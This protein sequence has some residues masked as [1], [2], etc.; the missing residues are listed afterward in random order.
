MAPLSD[1]YTLTVRQAPERAR[2]AG[3]KEKERKPVDPPPIVQL[4]IRDPLDLAQNYLQSPYL[5]MCANLCNADRHNPTQLASQSVLSGTLVSSLHRLKDVDNSD[6]GFFVFGDLSVKVEGDYCLRFSLFEMLKKRPTSSGIRSDEFPPALEDPPPPAQRDIPLQ[7]QRPQIGTYGTR[8]TGSG[9]P[10][11]KRQR[12]SVDM[13]ERSVIDP[14]R[15]SQRSYMDQR[16]PIGTYTASHQLAN[17]FAPT[18]SQGPPSALSNLSDF[19]FGHQRTNS[20]NTSSPFVSPHTDFSGHSWP[21]SN[22]YY[23][24]SA[25]DPLYTYSQSQYPDLQPPRQPQL[26]EPF[27]RQRVQD[28]SGRLQMNSNLSFPRPL[29]PESSAV[30]SYSQATRHLPMSSSYNDPSP[31]LPSTDQIGDLA[32]SNRQQYPSAPLSNVLPPLESPAGPSQSQGAQQGLTSNILPS[33]EPSNLLPT[34][35]CKHD[36]A[37]EILALSSPVKKARNP[38]ASA[39]ILA[40]LSPVLHKSIIQTAIVVWLGMAAPVDL[41]LVLGERLESPSATPKLHAK[42]LQV[43]AEGEE[44]QEQ[45]AIVSL[46]DVPDVH[47]AVE[48]QNNILHRHS[49]NQTDL[50]GDTLTVSEVEDY[51]LQSIGTATA[52]NEW[53]PL[54]ALSGNEA[55]A[56]LQTPTRKPQKSAT[57]PRHTKDH[58]HHTTSRCV[59]P[60]TSG[61][62]SQAARSVGRAS[63]CKVTA[64]L[65]SGETPSKYYGHRPLSVTSIA[66]SSVESPKAH[67][68]APIVADTSKPQPSPSN[69]H[70]QGQLGHKYCSSDQNPSHAPACQWSPSESP[71][72]WLRGSALSPGY[73]SPDRVI[74]GSISKQG[75]RHK[76]NDGNNSDPTVCTVDNRPM[77]DLHHIERWDGTVAIY[78]II[79]FRRSGWLLVEHN[80]TFTV[81]N[82][83][84][85]RAKRVLLKVFIRNG[86]QDGGIYRLKARES[87]LQ[88]PNY[89]YTAANGSRVIEVLVE[90]DAKDLGN[91]LTI[92]F[93]CCCPGQKE[94][95]LP[96]PVIA[97]KFG[98]LLSEKIWLRKP[99]P[100]LLVHAVGRRFLS[101][102]KLSER[103][104]GKKEVLCFERIE[105]SPLYPEA[106]KED[107][108]V[109]LCKLRPVSWAG[110]EVSRDFTQEEK[111]CNIIP[112][113]DMSIDIIPE[114]RL[115]CCMTFD[116]EVGDCQ[117]LLTIDA[118]GWEANYALVNG[119]LCGGRSTRWGTSRELARWLED[120]YRLALVKSPRMTPGKL[121][122]IEVSFIVIGPLSD[123]AVE[124]DNWVEI[125]FYLPRIV[126]K[127][128][129][130]GAVACSYQHASVAVTRPGGAD[131]EEHR[132]SSSHGG[133]RKRLPTL[134]RGYRLRLDYATLNPFR[135]TNT[136][137]SKPTMTADKI[138]FAGGLPLRPRA[139]RFDDEQSGTS[140]DVDD[141]RIESDPPSVRSNP[142]PPHLL[143]DP[144]GIEDESTTEVDSKESLPSVVDGRLGL[145]DFDDFDDGSTPR[146]TDANSGDHSQKTGGGT[147]AAEY[148]GLAEQSYTAKNKGTSNEGED[149][150][151]SS[152]NEL[153]AEDHAP[154]DREEEEEEDDSGD[155]AGENLGPEPEDLFDYLVDNVLY[156][157]RYLERRSPMQYL[158]RFFILEC[159]C[160][161]LSRVSFVGQAG[162]ELQRAVPDVIITSSDVLLGDWDVHVRPD[163]GM[164]EVQVAHDP[165]NNIDQVV[166]E[167]HAEESKHRPRGQSLR[168]RLDL[169]LGWRPQGP[170]S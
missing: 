68:N 119:H 44:V 57:L 34:T 21:T 5:F 104:F 77:D 62:L 128:I 81:T 64:F 29:D 127:T 118:T 147:R 145:D 42:G 164:A 92:V 122:H 98:K 33:I 41:Q 71:R 9:E 131:Y 103:L 75:S 23:Q 31:R 138:R 110:L 47:G 169:A 170:V 84:E 153:G 123:P 12:T 156:L 159:I 28:L 152:D 43:L 130:G 121:L 72:I 7:S 124:Q 51:T 83:P 82:L 142:P 24:A 65:A 69:D 112:S 136:M 143:Q 14:D 49:T 48:D 97:P 11:A 161:G 151:N 78:S 32:A 125:N 35:L 129:L 58:N 167:A 89:E 8:Y 39:T 59:T 73:F 70:A 155:A 108:M 114:K 102:W 26:T 139:V 36:P 146:S 18:Y 133:N 79:T 137:A 53:S 116:L 117:R 16:A 52:S 106:L 55:E 115:E 10:S 126:D 99:S 144:E 113:L 38:R 22:N 93:T 166:A 25:K 76:L 154:L 37:S 17:S 66:H 15:Y 61:R 74:R 85:I 6:G 87:L 91:P 168:D 50:S 54:E 3:P 100:P 60:T 19:S 30:E 4:H 20:S 86:P 148:A 46:T 107:A 163:A 27:V 141:E 80:A 149:T 111:P 63:G 134:G 40:L 105:T 101:S 157:L 94:V 88:L 132:F 45:P 95:C 120:D 56:V 109:R 162:R 90:R 135:F 160:L 140:N 165:A 13:G 150:P 2:V 96:F 1:D 158:I 67:E